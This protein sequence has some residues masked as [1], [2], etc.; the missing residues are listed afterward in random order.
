MVIT[1]SSPLIHITKLGKLEY[2]VKLVGHI[3]IPKAVFEEVVVKGKNFNYSEA[4]TIEN[5]IKRQKIKVLSLEPFDTSFYP[6][7]GKGE[8][9]ALELAKQKK[10]LL[11]IDDN[12]ARNLAHLLQIEYQTTLTTVFELLISEVIDYSEYKSNLKQ[13]AEDSWISAD[14]I[15]EYLEKGDKFGR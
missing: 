4:F 2:L 3:N 15:Q 10:E 7:L 14:L 13:Y 9:E 6:P 5:Y 1:N 12:K 8:L 11:I